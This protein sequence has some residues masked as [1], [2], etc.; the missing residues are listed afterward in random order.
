VT[1][2]DTGKIEDDIRNFF[3][4][5]RSS[6]A[7]EEESEISKALIFWDNGEIDAAKLVFDAVRKDGYSS[8]NERILARAG[9]AAYSFERN[10]VFGVKS[11]LSAISMLLN[12]KCFDDFIQFETLKIRAGTKNEDLD[13]GIE[14]FK[15]MFPILEK[16]GNSSDKEVRRTASATRILS[17]FLLSKFYYNRNRWRE[18]IEELSGIEKHET[19]NRHFDM[20]SS[21]YLLMGEMYKSLEGKES[22]GA[23]EYSQK[24]G[25]TLSLRGTRWND[26]NEEERKKLII[27]LYGS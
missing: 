1:I 15:E 26:K 3:G 14:I 6:I 8:F 7:V 16:L 19:K 13:L 5:V 18:G 25:A 10:Q 27:S 21:V 12:E 17:G 2:E 11:S 20:L 24:W 4:Y 22:K 23:A 9:L